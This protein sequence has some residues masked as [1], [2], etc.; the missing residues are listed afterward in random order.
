MNGRIDPDQFAGQIHER[1]AAVTR[2]DGRIGLDEVGK[3][4]LTG[5]DGPIQS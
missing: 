1:P 3:G 5:F 2:I 4:T